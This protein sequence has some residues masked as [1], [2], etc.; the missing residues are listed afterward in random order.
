MADSGGGFSM[1]RITGSRS[2]LI[3]LVACA[4]AFIGSFL[5]WASVIG[6]SVSGTD[7]GD[8]TLTLILALATAA[9][10]VFLKDRARMISV[11]V[12]AALVVII[13]VVNIADINSIS[14]DFGDALSP[15]IGIGLWMVL[16]GGIAAAVG[17]FVKD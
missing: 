8:G 7:G 5:P 4:V 3:V 6:I 16:A 1:D 12:G 14:S 13:A 11:L 15:S 9:A 17:V 10:A 2:N